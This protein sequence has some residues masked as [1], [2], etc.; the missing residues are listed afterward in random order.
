M[1]TVDDKRVMTTIQNIKNHFFEELSGYYP[2][3]EIVSFF[4]MVC[5]NKLG[6]GRVDI[7]LNPHKILKKET[8]DSFENAIAELKQ[9]R[10]IQYILGKAQFLGL[11]L[12]INHHVLIPR[13]E[14][15]LLVE[16]IVH[17]CHRLDNPVIADIGTG[18]GC[19]AVS[20]ALAL[21]HATIYATD[22][23]S[24]ALRVAED[25][26]TRHQVQERVHLI[27]G[28][29]FH[30]LNKIG[31]RG[32]VSAVVSNPPYIADAEWSELQPEVGAFEP[33]LALDGG[34]DGLNVVNRLVRNAPSWLKPE[35]LLVVEVGRGQAER[36][37]RLATNMDEYDRV[38]VRQDHAGI[39]RVVCMTVRPIR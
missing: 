28:D 23:S 5:E 21:P 6:M 11:T 10:P 38:W 2:K 37:T 35:A 39:D 26:V 1:S 27:E 19:I 24:S 36:V 12:H 15:E 13:P 29:L 3:E 33:R 18:S 22:C 17:Y 14:T 34:P 16:S 7:A 9:N 25:N 4:T 31:V 30:P 8:F 32:Q 20:A